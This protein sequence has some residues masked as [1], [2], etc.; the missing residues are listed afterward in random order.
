MNTNRSIP[1]LSDL[2][3]ILTTKKDV[4]N[5]FIEE[6]EKFLFLLKKYPGLKAVPTK[7]ID[8]VWHYHQQNSI[9]YNEDCI[10][11]FG[12]TIKHKEA[13]TDRE[14]DQLDNWYQ[15]TNRLWFLNFSEY[16]GSKNDMAVCGVDGDGC[17]TGNDDY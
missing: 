16:L 4:S 3:K 5:N 14:I 2:R 11:I 12:Y 10:R 13:I 1:H 6:Y 7:E 9:L 8:I 17:D 15:L